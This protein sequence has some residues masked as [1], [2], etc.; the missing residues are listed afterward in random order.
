MDSLHCSRTP[1]VAAEEA[2][3][4]SGTAA[5]ASSLG[6]TTTAPGLGV[7][8]GARGACMDPGSAA[9]KR[10]YLLQMLIL[11][12]IPIAALIAQNSIMLAESR[13][14]LSNAHRLGTQV[15]QQTDSP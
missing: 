4:V 14:I 11:P 12:L 8:A 15:S 7:G 1:S 5:D 10:V 6:T 2:G 13:H 3:D 9:G